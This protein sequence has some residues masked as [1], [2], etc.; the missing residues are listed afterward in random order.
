MS[1][2]DDTSIFNAALGPRHIGAEGEVHDVVESTMDLARQRCAEGVE[3]GYVVLAEHQSAGRGRTGAW[4]CPPGLGVLMS[5]VLR[6]GVPSTR[7]HL[8]V[9]MAAAACV[10]ALR[11]LG[12][13]AS[14]KWP[15]DIVVADEHN[16]R[17][18]VRKLGGLIVERVQPSDGPASHVLGMG[19]N[20]NQQTEHLPPQT[21]VSATSMRLEKGREFDR[22]AV[23]RALLHELDTWYRILARGQEERILA[24]WRKRSCLP[25]HQ[26]LVRI[27]NAGVQA[28]VEG[29]RATGEI[30]LR[31]PDG[32][33]QAFTD[34]E[35]KLLFS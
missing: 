3:D 5:V 2:L 26:V 7:Q 1:P 35:V 22:N 16:G 17:L 31:M 32:R 6:L 28:T 21:E 11:G 9:S 20:V 33:R 27:G 14:I 15:N 4:Q 34:S 13:D 25:G 30:I 12:V 8:V 18:S 23:C 19:L 10:E 29:I 24:R